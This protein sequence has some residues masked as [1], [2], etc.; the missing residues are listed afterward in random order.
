[1]LPTTDRS[2]CPQFY[3]SLAKIMSE[4][5]DNAKDWHRCRQMDIVELTSRMNASSMGSPSPVR[6]RPTV[7]TPKRTT[8]AQARAQEAADD[9]D[10]Q[11]QTSHQPQWGE[12]QGGSIR[13]SD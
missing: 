10:Q 13:F 11:T 8:R 7:A 12:W 4:L 5:R 3:N 9:A 2:S 1:M 6:P